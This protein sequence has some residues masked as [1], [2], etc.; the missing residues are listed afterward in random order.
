MA[1]EDEIHAIRSSPAIEK[2]R[3]GSGRIDRYLDSSRDDPGT[4][5]RARTF[6]VELGPHHGTPIRYAGSLG[7]TRG[8]RERQLRVE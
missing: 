4:K 8:R 1:E 5:Q 2:D 6:A 3:H 7:H